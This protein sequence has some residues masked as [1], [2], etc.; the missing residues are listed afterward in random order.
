MQ[1]KNDMG[2]R[3]IYRVWFWLRAFGVDCA[4]VFYG[5]K[6][7]PRYLADYYILRSQM[8][9]LSNGWRAYLSM[10][11]FEDRYVQSGKA[12]GHYFH[13]DLLVAR[14]VYENNPRRHVDVGSSVAGFVSHLAVF[15]EVEVLDIRPLTT[16]ASNIIFRQCD[17][18]KMPSEFEASCDSL[19]CLHALEHFGLGRYSDQIDVNGHLKGLKNLSKLLQPGGILYL[20]VP[21]GRQRIEFNAHR[22]FAISTV[23]SMLNEDFELIEF[24]YIDD[25]GALHEG[26][27]LKPKSDTN[28]FD[29]QFGCGIFLCK[30][31]PLEHS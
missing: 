28:N 29:L 20:S 27:D 12:S 23:L 16:T 19:S 1:A 22:V 2:R 31:R 25:A 11:C 5:L 26:V 17:L 14:K 13:Q 6:G 18:M 9:S 30:K 24:S 8:R 10:P 21:I 7:L 4:S 15:R 3:H